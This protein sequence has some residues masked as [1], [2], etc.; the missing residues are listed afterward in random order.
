MCNIAG[1]IGSKKATPILFEMIKKQEGYAGGYYAGIATI[2]DNKIYSHKLTGSIDMLENTFAKDFEGNIGIIHTRSNA[3]GGDE[4]A[5]PFLGTKNGE[6]ITAYVAVGCNGYFTSRREEFNQIPKELYNEGYTML[7]AT[8]E[9]ES[10]LYPSMPDGAKVHMSDVMCNLIF[11]NICDGF[12]SDI[13]MAKAF[14]QMPGEIIGLNLH[15]DEDDRIAWAKVS[16]AIF[17]SFASHGVYIASS[18]EAFPED[19]GQV[20]M[21]PPNSS[22]YIYKDHYTVIPFKNNPC[23]V[24]ELDAGFMKENYDR[25]YEL[26]K[27]ESAYYPLWDT[28]KPQFTGADVYQVSSI[29]NT[30]IEALKREG[31]IEM[32]TIEVDGAKDGIKAKQCM[33]KAK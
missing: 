2:K 33:F 13:A 14:C 21:L 11:K 26:L 9:V 1:Y 7:S 28:I 16:D 17:V 22:G 24:R 25:I 3:G 4:W 12:S 31:K 19:A 15:K 5:H 32:R 18:P 6:V 10:D 27:E 23:K 20:H 29:L 8:K 30:V